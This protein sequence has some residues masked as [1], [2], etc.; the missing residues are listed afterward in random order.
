[1]AMLPRVIVHSA[2]SADGRTSLMSAD[3][4]LFYSLARTWHEQATLTG[5]DTLSAAYPPAA[6]K[7]VPAG[8][9]P[10]PVRGDKRPLLVAT[11]SR[12]RLKC[13]PQLLREPYWRGGVALVTHATP[14]RY[15][16]LIEDAGA[17]AIIA[18]RERVDLREALH[19]LRGRY[20]TRV[21]RVDS[22]GAL[23][24]ALLAEGLVDELSLLVCP[25]LT[26]GHARTV[27]G[28]RPLVGGGDRPL[29]LISCEKLERGHVWLRY[30]VAK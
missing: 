12:G 25:C 6:L 15:L 18:G 13:W 21:I 23:S 4:G 22:G 16:K 30:K 11:D 20:K 5:A 9:A 29:K 24:G 2:V 27:T 7:D 1:M 19:Q 8:P 10:P 28:A 17:E 3:P 26:G 14:A